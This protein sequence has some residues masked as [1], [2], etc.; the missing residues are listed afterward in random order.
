M[1]IKL[2]CELCRQNNESYQKNKM[3]VLLEI[4]KFTLPAA[5]MLVAV[6]LVI[7]RFFQQEA[8][9]L[10]SDRRQ[11]MRREIFPVRLQAYERIVLLLERMSPNQLIL[12]VNRQGINLSQ[13]QSLLIQSVRDEF[14]HNLSQQVYISS[15]AWN[16]TKSAKEEIIRLINT[17]AAGLEKESPAAGLATKLLELYTGLDEDPVARAIEYIKQEARTFL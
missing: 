4:I 1:T 15:G 3:T 9:R 16:L 13:F 17:A 7:Q 2:I 6:Y 8:L 11:T 14:D 10:E 5:I 12:R